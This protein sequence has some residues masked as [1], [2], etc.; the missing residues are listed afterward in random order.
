[1]DDDEKKFLRE[2]HLTILSSAGISYIIGIDN[3]TGE[4]RIFQINFDR[5]TDP[6]T[7]YAIAEILK[8]DSSILNDV[9]FEFGEVEDEFTV[10]YREKK[11]YDKLFFWK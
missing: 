4:R 9:T 8:E 6:P 3:K 1:M 5:S 2:I 7:I 11:W 10:N